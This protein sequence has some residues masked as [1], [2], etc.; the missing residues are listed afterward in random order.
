MSE[1]AK[2]KPAGSPRWQKGLPSPNPAGRPRKDKTPD[3]ELLK[4]QKLLRKHTV[5]AVQK[6]IQL[7]QNAQ[8]PEMQLK[9]STWIVDKCLVVDKEVERRNLSQ[10]PEEP[11]AGVDKP[12]R[13]VLSL[14][15]T[16]PSGVTKVDVP[17]DE[18]REDDED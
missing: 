4:M 10:P 7:M 18:E 15:M 6:V 5:E 9:T 3:A 16:T 17:L 2:K 14:K 12:A 1:E 11:A 8:T 13:P